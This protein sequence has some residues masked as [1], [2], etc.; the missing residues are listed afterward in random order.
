MPRTAR[1]VLP[2]YPHHVV[3][4]GHNR[5]AVF[6]ATGDYMEFNNVSAKGPQFNEHVES[7]VWFPP[8]YFGSTSPECPIGS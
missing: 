1:V 3:Q 5:Q 7:S 4:R 6:A 8:G 2:A